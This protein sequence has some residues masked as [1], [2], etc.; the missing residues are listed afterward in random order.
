MGKGL[1]VRFLCFTVCMGGYRRDAM[2]TDWEADWAREEAT[3]SLRGG[4]C[5][6]TTDRRN[7]LC[8]GESA[9]RTRVWSLSSMT[10]LPD[11]LGDDK[12][13]SFEW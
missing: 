13:D 12:R 10:Q 7:S 6:R 1:V 8:D 2:Q 11:V 4:R 3:K 9:R 5:T